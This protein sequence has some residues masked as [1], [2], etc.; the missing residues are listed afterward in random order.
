MC[1]GVVAVENTMKSP[2]PAPFPLRSIARTSVA[3]CASIA[4]T[5]SSTVRF[6][7]DYVAISYVP[8]VR[9]RIGGGGGVR[10]GSWSPRQT[11]PRV[12][13]FHDT[14]RISWR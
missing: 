12:A 10:R 3:P 8:H 4:L 14:D 2:M 13:I 1:R 6:T 9:R 11:Q 5:T 7:L